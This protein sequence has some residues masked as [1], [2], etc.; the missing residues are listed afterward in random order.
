MS[1][2]ASY[3]AYRGR[4]E[5]YFDRTALA[6][7]AQLTSDAPVSKIR[8]TVRAGRD[9][10]RSSLLDWLPADLTGRRILDAGCGTG[11]LAVE[12]AKRGADVVAIDIS[13]QLIGIARERMPASLK[14]DWRVGDSFDPTLG[15]FD[16]VISMD[17]LI[18]YRAEDIVRVI[19]TLAERTL[20]SIAFTFA[21]RTP[22]LGAML[23][24]GKYF[25]KR[26][27]SPTLEAVAEAV[28]RQKLGNI[29][30]WSVARDRFVSAGFYKSHA[31]ELVK[32]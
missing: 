14:I 27:S 21:P 7:W 19:E 22:I 18:H 10:M 24:V 5:T 3:D 12:A 4:L 20:T 29:A 6:A 13:G 8:A 28:L 32:S 15:S 9:K 25:P 1:R 16:H 2:S 31:L 17:V 26:D 11:A 23:A 30:G